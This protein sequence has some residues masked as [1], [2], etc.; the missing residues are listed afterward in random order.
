M[1]SH[2]IIIGA[3][4]KN[5]LTVRKPGYGTMRLTGEDF[6]GEPK[7]RK[8]AIALLKEAAHLGVNFFDTADFYGPGVTNKLPCEALYPYAATLSLRQ[9]SEL[10]VAPIK[11][12]YRMEN[13]KSLE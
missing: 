13:L 9:K 3:G 6:Y 11:A 8:G 5:P 4:T 7:D 10:L 2:T 12:G 1:N